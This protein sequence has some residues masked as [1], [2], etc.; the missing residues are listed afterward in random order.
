M[1]KVDAIIKHSLAEKEELKK[2]FDRNKKIFE[3]NIE[4]II[5]KR[6]LEA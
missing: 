1:Q 6:I 5:E 2:I 3:V 4:K